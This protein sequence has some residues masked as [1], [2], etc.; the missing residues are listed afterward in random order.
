MARKPNDPLDRSHHGTALIR[1][2]CKCGAVTFAVANEKWPPCST[3]GSQRWALALER[4]AP[5][6]SVTPSRAKPAPVATPGT[7]PRKKL[8]KK[9][10][11]VRGDTLTKVTREAGVEVGGANLGT[12]LAEDTEDLTSTSPMEATP[13][14]RDLSKAR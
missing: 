4:S 7:Q 10:A 1:L 14:V 11:R 12:T 9:P 8:A 13:T 2:G 5:A 3:C 6:K